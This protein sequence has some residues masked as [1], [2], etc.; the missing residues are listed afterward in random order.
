MAGATAC[1]QRARPHASFSAAASAEGR[2]GGAGWEEF[3]EHKIR[4][5]KY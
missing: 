5:Q 3:P 2:A 4:R 1:R